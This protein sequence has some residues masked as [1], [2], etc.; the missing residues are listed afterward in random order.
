MDNELFPYDQFT[1]RD[2]IKNIFFNYL[3]GISTAKG[4]DLIDRLEEKFLRE[5]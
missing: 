1:R 5:N 3:R 2:V 4:L